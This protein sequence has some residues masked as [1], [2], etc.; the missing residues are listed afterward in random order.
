MDVGYVYVGNLLFVGDVGDWCVV[1]VVVI[2]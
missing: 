2:V 1:I